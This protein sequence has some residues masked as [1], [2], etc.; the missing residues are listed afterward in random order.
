[1]VKGKGSFFGKK[2]SKAEQENDNMVETSN[3]E[4]APRNTEN[5]AEPEEFIENGVRSDHGNGNENEEA[6][7]AEHVINPENNTDKEEIYKAQISDLQDKYVRLMAEFDNFRKRSLKERAELI[8]SAGDDVLINIL[9]VMDD[10]ERGITA[11]ETSQDIEA[12]K[13][14][15]LLIYNKF[16]DFL[17]LRGVKEMDALNQDFNVDVHEALT[18]IPAPEEHLKGKVVDVIQKGYTLNDKVIR[19]AK[20]VVGE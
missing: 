1:M 12:V 2:D 15:I 18:K 3:S 6:Q 5:M 8:K 19:Y 4:N 10:F 20:V 9:P 16:K 11:M 7:S 13:Q 17:I 14:G